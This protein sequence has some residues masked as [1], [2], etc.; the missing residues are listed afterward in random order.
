MASE[1][2]VRNSAAWRLAHEMNLRVDV[3]LGCPDFR[4]HFKACEALRDAARSGPRSIAEGL[5][6]RNRA[7]VAELIR[8]AC[9]AQKT[10]LDHLIDAHQQH[11]ITTDELHI[12]HALATR[13]MKAAASLIDLLPE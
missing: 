11:L 5:A 4:R 7:A 13:A 1:I 12:N 9:E 3:F 10:V 8:A 6:R 2:D